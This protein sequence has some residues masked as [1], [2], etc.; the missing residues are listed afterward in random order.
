MSNVGVNKK[1]RMESVLAGI[2]GTDFLCVKKHNEEDWTKGVM[3]VKTKTDPPIFFEIEEGIIT[4]ISSFNDEGDPEIVYTKEIPDW[5][6][7]T[8]VKIDLSQDPIVMKKI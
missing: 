2:K 4:D 1:T 5:H 7:G 8:E 3:T 6:V